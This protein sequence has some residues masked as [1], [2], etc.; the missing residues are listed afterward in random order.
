M[1]GIPGQAVVYPDGTTD[2]ADVNGIVEVPSRFITELLD[3]GLVFLTL[4]IL[5]EARVYYVRPDGSDHNDGLADTVA[6]AWRTVQHAVDYCAAN[7]SLPGVYDKVGQAAATITLTIQVGDG[8]YAEQVSLRQVQG[9]RPLLRGNVTTPALVELA[10]PSGNSALDCTGRGNQWLVRGLHV[11]G[12]S[13]D[14]FGAVIDAQNGGSIWWSNLELT[15]QHAQVAALRS[16]FGSEL[17]MED[18]A[19]PTMVHGTA[20]SELFFAYQGARLDFQAETLTL[21]DA[22][23]FADAAA[24]A[25][26]GSVITFFIESLVGAATGARYTVAELS[27]IDTFGGGASALPGDAPGSADAATGGYYA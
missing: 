17:I 14:P 19:A 25:G 12:T 26:V 11:N 16:A 3:A 27:L 10:A 24:F 22:L 13:V 8:V 4:E 6:G 23:A 20:C 21:T 15:V 5:T 1:R 2:R 7:L 18:Y 9:G